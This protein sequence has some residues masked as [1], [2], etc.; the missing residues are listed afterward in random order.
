MFEV[1][2]RVIGN[3]R[4]QDAGYLKDMEEW[5]PEAMGYMRTKYVTGL[6]FQ[7]VHIA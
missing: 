4:V 7:D 1:I 5:I 6:T 2:A 3:T